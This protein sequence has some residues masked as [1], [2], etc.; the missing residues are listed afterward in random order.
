MHRSA[1]CRHPDSMRCAIAAL[2]GPRCPRPLG[3]PARRPRRRHP[4]PTRSV[5]STGLGSSPATPQPSASGRAHTRTNATAT[6]SGDS[7]G[8]R[9]GAR[10]RRRGRSRRPRGL[11]E[12]RR[13]PCPPSRRARPLRSPPANRPRLRG[14]RRQPTS[15]AAPI[16]V[17]ARFRQDH[18]GHRHQPTSRMPLMTHQ[19][20][21]RR[22]RLRRCSMA[23]VRGS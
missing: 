2:E 1:V 9:G 7:G 22:P 19:H 17:T 3:M 12:E 13:M 11:G 23:P 10:R 8:R 21:G 6:S 5:A 16:T 15:R 20:P 14:A 18:R 4:R